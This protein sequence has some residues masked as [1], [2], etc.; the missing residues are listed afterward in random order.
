LPT[1]AE[2]DAL[3]AKPRLKMSTFLQFLKETGADSGEAQKLRWIDIN[4][5][6]NTVAITP[7]KNHNAR[8]L[9][10][11]SKLISRL[12][13][14]PRRSDFVFNIKSLDGFRAGY[15]AMKNNLSLELGNA[16]IAEIAFRTFRHWKATTEYS[17]T[18]DILHVKH[19][20]GHKRLEN[21]LVY[22]HLV[23][24]GTDDY[25]CKTATTLQDASVLIESGFDYI[26]E[27]DGIKLFRKRK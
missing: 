23:P 2:L 12:L 14:L 11:S 8:T 18:K 19:L 21:T 9:K 13:Q 16:R 22:T 25:I 4:A 26:T 15:E 27:M 6:N 17:K 10:V 20:L 24:S 5:E 7:T 3:I 1:E